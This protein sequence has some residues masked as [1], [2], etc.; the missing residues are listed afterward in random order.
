MLNQNK[1]ITV[2]ITAYKEGVLLE[3][4]WK[5]VVDQTNSQWE[6]VMVLD[7]GADK[8][9]KQVFNGISH[10]FLKKIKLDENQG[11]YYSRTLAIENT[12]T[13]WYCHLDADDRLPPNMVF[14]IHL[15]IDKYFDIKYI[16]GRCLY[17]NEQIFKIKDHNGISDERLVYTLPFNGQGPIKKEL[18]TQL[19]GYC[20]DLYQGGAD[21]DFWIGVLESGEKGKYI[22]DIIYER[23][24]RINSVGYNRIHKRQKVV[25]IVIKRH[26]KFFNGQDRKKLANYKVHELMARNYRSKG[27]REDAYKQAKKSMEYGQS[28][29][30]LNEIIKEFNMSPPR[31]ALRRLGRFISR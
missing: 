16:I 26:P 19:G 8:K 30:T 22:D 18:L 7:G 13:D 14:N 21:W 25:E 4:A 31:Y 20:K 12:S 27:N 28:T 3:E 15:A 10:P 5:S 17:F 11:P 1:K 2:G 9:T 24:E 23:R 6:A 29:P